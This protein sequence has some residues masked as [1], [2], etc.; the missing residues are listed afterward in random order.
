VTQELVEKHWD[1]S[2][3]AKYYEYRPNYNSKAIDLLT[4][5]VSAHQSSDFQIADIGAGTG[6]LTIMLLER[7]FTVTAVEPND[8]MREIGIERTATAQN[9]KWIKANGVDTTLADSYADWVNLWK[10]L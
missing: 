9:V 7:G 6:N 1:Y 10:Q 4:H 5:Y 2:Q 8:E 3:H